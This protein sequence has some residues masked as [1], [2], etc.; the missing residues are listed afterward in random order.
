MQVTVP[1]SLPP[2]RGFYREMKARLPC[3]KGQKSLPARG[4]GR[5]AGEQGEVLGAE[6][7]IM[8]RWVQLPH[9]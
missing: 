4:L 3:S 7:G 6:M 2:S 9:G 1:A 5:A 8:G